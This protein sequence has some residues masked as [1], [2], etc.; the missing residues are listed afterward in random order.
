M[1]LPRYVKKKWLEWQH[2]I[3]V[4]YLYLFSLLI[5]LYFDI[6]KKSNDLS[7]FAVKCLLSQNKFINN[8]LLYLLKVGI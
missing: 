6:E 5:L 7:L 3:N 1:L 8:N 2:F 4:I